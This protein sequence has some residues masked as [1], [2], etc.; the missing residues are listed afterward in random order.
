MEGCREVKGQE[1]DE[2]CDIGEI[3]QS[4]RKF[5]NLEIFKLLQKLSAFCNT[6]KTENQKL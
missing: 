1:G 4:V 2:Q 3:L 6:C 5:T